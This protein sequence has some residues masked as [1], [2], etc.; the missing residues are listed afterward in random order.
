MSAN[1]QSA[2]SEKSEKTEAAESRAKENAEREAMSQGS[3]TEGGRNAIIGDPTPTG[4]SQFDRER[5]LKQRE[6]TH[7]ALVEQEQERVDETADGLAES[8]EQQAALNEEIE[9]SEQESTEV[10]TLTVE[11]PHGETLRFSVSGKDY[12]VKG[13]KLPLDKLHPGHTAAMVADAARA[14]LGGLGVTIKVEEAKRKMSASASRGFD[15]QHLLGDVERN[16]TPRK[17][18]EQPFRVPND[19]EHY[20]EEQLKIMRVN[21]DAMDQAQALGLSPVRAIEYDPQALR[22]GDTSKLKKEGA[23]R[24]LAS[25]KKK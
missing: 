24:R 7:K 21:W 20:T 19:T 8:L 4:P 3:F 11:S 10:D 9:A 1:K 2:K 17:A 13:G 6:I 5:L 16:I 18:M 12:F 25:A 23:E 15:S 22:E 14:Q